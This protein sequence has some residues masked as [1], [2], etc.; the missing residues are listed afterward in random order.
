M[1]ILLLSLG[2][3]FAQELEVQGDLKVTGTVDVNGN[4][5]TN[6]GEPILTTDVATAN[7]VNSRTSSKGRIIKLECVWTQTV[8]TS[9]RA[10]TAVST[11]SCEPS[12]CG[13]G[14]VDYGVLSNNISIYQ[15]LP[16]SDS[17]G[18]SYY[19]YFGGNTTRYCLEQE[20]EE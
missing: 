2:I 15:Y 17:N 18:S 11:A 3:L 8:V 16:Y 4:P 1:R 20:D 9:S 19:H 5:I 10:Q 13:E 14:W 12:V 7:Y 6:V